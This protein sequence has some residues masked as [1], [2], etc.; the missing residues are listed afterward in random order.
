MSLT[1]TMTECSRCG[2]DRQTRFPCPECGLRP[3][4]TEVDINVQF[5]QNAVRPAR[6]V[7][8]GEATHLDLDAHELLSSGRLEDLPDRILAVGDSI[9]RREETGPAQLVELAA[10]IA[11]LGH[12]TQ[13]VKRLR[14][15]V[16]LSD[17]VVVVVNELIKVFD[18]A[19]RALLSEEIRTAQRCEGEIQA[20]LDRAASAI[21]EANRRLDLMSLIIDADDPTGTWMAVAIDGDPTTALERGEALFLS[22]TGLRCGESAA[23]TALMMAPM[24]AT[25]GDEDRW[26]NL[27][28][29]HIRFLDIYRAALAPVLQ[30][31]AFASRRSDVVHDLWLSA[32]RASRLPSPE[33][34][35]QDASDLLD[36]GHLVVEQLLKFNLGLGCA[37]TTSRSFAATQGRDVSDLA[38]VA[39]SQGWPIAQDLG[40]SSIR[41]AFAH[42]DYTIDGDSVLL[43]PARSNPTTSPRSLTIT[44][45]S[46]SVLEIIEVSAAMELAT[47]W[48]TEQVDPDSVFVPQGII[49]AESLLIGFGW[50]D[51]SIIADAEDQV[52]ISACVDTPLP[53]AAI[54]FAI[55][56]LVGTTRELCLHL[57]SRNESN[58]CIAVVPVELFSAWQRTESEPLKEASFVHLCAVTTIDESPI[59]SH[60]HVR[61]VIGIRTCQLVV[62]EEQDL[63]SVCAAL[64]IWRSAARALD[65]PDLAREIGRA[66]RLR[67]Y[68]AAG[69]P[70]TEAD[71]PKLLAHVEADLPSPPTNLLS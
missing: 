7:R 8:E 1:F 40:D 67:R 44:E 20:A 24:M 16:F 69:L 30:D 50:S 45:L 48:L 10:E 22:R 41:N 68:R 5:R 9:G 64:E 63:S 17:A 18:I 29:K 14:P 35:R 12:W 2:A 57:K 36:L 31:P 70:I 46:D 43:S 4:P 23:L 71:T 21:G 19:L 38:S 26:W 61:K 62:D 51:V 56:P 13:G 60:D 37:L 66:I 11:S 6:R 42:R 49:F 3:R 39:D 27:V 65:F 59:L 25:I 54:A 32:R 47:V 34:L 52:T 28:N 15:W 55:A 58:E 53:L 33:T